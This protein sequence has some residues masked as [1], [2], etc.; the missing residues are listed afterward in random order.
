MSRCEICIERD[1]HDG[2]TRMCREPAVAESTDTWTGQR[3][4]VCDYHATE[5]RA[6]G[7]RV[8]HY[9]EVGHE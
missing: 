6:E 3:A 1:P 9:E 4:Q 2:H 8:S 5:A 7:A